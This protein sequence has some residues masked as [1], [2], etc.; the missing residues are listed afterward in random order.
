[1]YISHVDADETVALWVFDQ[2]TTAEWDAHL[3]D[4]QKYISGFKP[5]KRGASLIIARDFS[6]PDS[7]RRVELVRLTGQANFDPFVAFISPNAALR[8]ILAVFGWMQ[9]APR[10]E[11]DFFGSSA[12]GLSWLQKKRDEPLPK[13]TANL[14]SA[15]AEFKEKTGR[16]LP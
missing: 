6:R 14:A 13:L 4:L 15:V 9:K 7:K 16:D 12:A 11:V 8:A 5:G 1:M 10:Y 3:D 2:M